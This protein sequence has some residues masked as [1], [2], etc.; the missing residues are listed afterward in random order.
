MTILADNGSNT[1]THP[2][3]GIHSYTNSSIDIRAHQDNTVTTTLPAQ[4]FGIFAE[5]GGVVNMTA[6]TGSNTLSAD[7]SV[8]GEKR[9]KINL[10]APQG[11]NEIKG[12]NIG[13]YMASGST[14]DINNHSVITAG[15]ALQAEGID[16]DEQGNPVGDA[17]QINVNYTG[18]SSVT[19]IILAYNSGIVNVNP[20]D[21]TGTENITGLIA[22]TGQNPTI[23]PVTSDEIAA[24][25]ATYVGGTVSVDLNDGSLFTGKAL[26]ALDLGT[27]HNTEREG[28]IN[29][30]LAGSAL[31]NMTGSSSVTRLSGTGTV[32]YNSGGNAL[33]VVNLS[34]SHTFEMDLSTTGSNSDMLYVMNSTGDRQF[35][36]IKNFTQLNSEMDPGSAVR[37]AVFRNGHD[38]FRDGT[39]AGTYANGVYNDTLTIRTRNIDDD[40]D[41]N[42][43]Y[44][45]AYN[46]SGSVDKPTS[47]TVQTLYYSADS[48]ND[49]VNPQNVYVVKSRT[50]NDGGTTPVKARQLVWRYGTDLDTFTK[51]EGQTVYITPDSNNEGYWF[52]AAHSKVGIDGVGS[53]SGNSFELGF[54]KLEKNETE[55][56]Q[57]WGLSARYGRQTG[58]WD[59]TYG[60]LR[61][62]DGYIGWY[63]TKEYY[64]S[65]EKQ[66]E[67]P[68]WKRD[69]HNYWDTF[70]KVHRLKTEY[71]VTDSATGVEYAGRFH[72]FMVNLST[73]YGRKIPLSRTWYWTPQAQIQLSLFEGYKY[74]DSQGLQTR[75]DDSW[76]LIGRLGFDLVHLLDEE[77]DAKIY[78]KASV[79]HE[80]LD[81]GNVVTS[82][83][84]NS[85]TWLLNKGDQSG[86]WAVVGFGLSTRIGN[87]KDDYIFLDAEQAFGN[88]FESTFNIRAGINLN[89]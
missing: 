69:A 37:F 4:T 10:S 23:D 18:D 33:Q 65:E 31:W 34:G 76:S 78:L 56:K 57:R 42:E 84:G 80:F 28:I 1:V 66:K 7:Y 74:T 30:N 21:D 6:A 45:N 82:S 60:D 3:I 36:K 27:D 22:A 51:R 17:A 46:G 2:H 86:T 25:P 67:L 68:E 14:A 63:N 48:D 24:E 70:L 39:V 35:L 73:E 47:E 15:T 75:A 12:G 62:N 11:T 61:I 16:D 49:T 40:P 58:H 20:A 26:T 52:R 53:T 71:D 29:L 38:E 19:G 43:T 77:S 9:S 83:T 89:F 41:N 81:G 54:S 32:H 79:L 88:D 44:N 64:S 85:D 55:K 72:N 5:V 59:G 50:E 8:Y 87:G 13:T